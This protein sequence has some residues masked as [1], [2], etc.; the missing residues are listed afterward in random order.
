MK[1]MHNTVTLSGH[2]GSAIELTQL[3]SGKRVA[4]VAI[5]TNEYYR[6][7]EG[8]TKKETQWHNLV[9]WDDTAE[10]MQ[11]YLAK[12]TFVIIHG[13]LVHRPYLDRNGNTQYFS[14]VLV[15][16][17]TRQKPAQAPASTAA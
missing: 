15:R 16:E 1:T 5:A 14:E 3:S 13:K 8:N 10:R 11:R 7:K 12:G 4:R 9:A 6:D 2:L 17:F